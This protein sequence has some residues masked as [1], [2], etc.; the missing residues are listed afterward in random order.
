VQYTFGSQGT[1]VPFPPS[2]SFGLP[3]WL[4]ELPSGLLLLD[5]LHAASQ[6]NAIVPMIVTAAETG[7]LNMI[8]SLRAGKAL[9]DG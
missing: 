2:E 1:R 6:P 3:S 7:F 8:L 4:F 9:L 5:E